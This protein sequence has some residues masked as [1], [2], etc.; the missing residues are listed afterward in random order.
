MF[1]KPIDMVK[2]YW[3]K[4]CTHS[5]F[6]FARKNDTLYTMKRCNDRDLTKHPYSAAEIKNKV[7]FKNARTAMASLTTQQV[8]AY[9]A[10][11]AADPNTKYAYLQGYIFAQEYTK[12]KAAYELA[13]PVQS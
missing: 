7:V 10:A 11:W 9:K 12:A 3:G 1:Y 8:A 4:L 2:S 13:N 6:S 5:D